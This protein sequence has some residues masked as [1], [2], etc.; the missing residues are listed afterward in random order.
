MITFLEDAG[1]VDAEDA[2]ILI[3]L[4]EA[5][6]GQAGMMVVLLLERHKGNEEDTRFLVRWLGVWY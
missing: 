3:L 6:G 4:V 5:H 1:P 2:G